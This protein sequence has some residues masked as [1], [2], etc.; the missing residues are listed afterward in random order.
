MNISFELER[1][2]LGDSGNLKLFC[3]YLCLNCFGFVA[4]SRHVD[5][6]PSLNKHYFFLLHNLILRQQLK[7]FALVTACQNGQ[8]RACPGVEPGTSRTLSENH[9]TRPTGRYI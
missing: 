1:V 4:L 8:N 3:F 6:L 2:A 5:D 9:T 7:N